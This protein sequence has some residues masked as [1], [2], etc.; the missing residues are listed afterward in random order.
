MTL[1]E[2]TERVETLEGGWNVIAGAE[3]ADIVRAAR[4]PTPD[5]P[6]GEIYG[7]GDAASRIVTAM[8]GW[9]SQ[10]RSGDGVQR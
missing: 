2:E 9:A 4:R 8:V 3:T 6:R 10:T 7:D 5:A 1:R